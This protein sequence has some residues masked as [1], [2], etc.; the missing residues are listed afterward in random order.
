MRLAWTMWLCRTSG[1]SF[2][3]QPH[4]PEQT[5]GIGNAPIHLER[6]RGNPET[7]GLESHRAQGG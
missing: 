7:P 6:I 2:P 4:Q 3:H 5:P 1:R